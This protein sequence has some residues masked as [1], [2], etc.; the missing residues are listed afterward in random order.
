MP[1]QSCGHQE[2]WCKFYRK[3]FFFLLPPI[4]LLNAACSRQLKYLAPS[5]LL[6]RANDRKRWSK[7]PQ[8]TYMK[9][10]SRCC[11]KCVSV[12]RTPSH[13]HPFCSSPCK[14]KKRKKYVSQER[15]VFQFPRLQPHCLNADWRLFNHLR[16]NV[17]AY[18]RREKIRIR[19]LSGCLIMKIQRKRN[20]LTNNLSFRSSKKT[21]FTRLILLE[22]YKILNN[23]LTSKPICTFP[24]V[25]R[26]F[27]KDNKWRAKLLSLSVGVNLK[28]GKASTAG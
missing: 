19:F 24:Q 12:T 8:Y 17:C 3:G 25:V 21:D 16:E 14:K 15:F 13:T 4:K 9:P 11:L 22:V 1:H 10:V 23:H 28:P 27:L 6:L 26:S 7:E 18:L 5:P 2:H 20:T